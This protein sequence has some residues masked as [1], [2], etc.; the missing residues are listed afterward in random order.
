MRV[1][2]DLTA[3]KNWAINHGVHPT[4]VAFL[5]FMPDDLHVIDLDRPND[6]IACPRNWVKLSTQLINMEK[7]ENGIVTD[8]DDL[9]FAACSCVGVAC[10]PHFVSFYKYN[11]SV[12]NAE[13]ILDGKASPDAVKDVD[14]EV[15][16]I[17]VQNLVSC[18][19]KELQM[20]K[21]GDDF[22]DKAVNRV[23]NVCNWLI[24]VGRKYR[25]DFAVMAFQDLGNNVSDF[26]MLLMKDEFDEKCPEFIEFTDENNVMFRPS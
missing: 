19:K 22:S 2:E 9:E 13:D 3:W 10:G 16:Y 1:E 4:V 12:I 8:E 15:M 14:T 7:M 11:K 20:N 25:L 26:H 5:S 24:T 21:N 17:I 6:M 18:I 23:I